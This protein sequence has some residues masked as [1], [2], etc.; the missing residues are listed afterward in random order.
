MFELSLIEEAFLAQ[1]FNSW[2]GKGQNVQDKTSEGEDCQGKYLQ[3]CSV[4]LNE[5][6]DTK[7]W[8][9]IVK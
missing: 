7:E 6:I 3:Y 1:G 5:T 4:T 2:L 8:I 9:A